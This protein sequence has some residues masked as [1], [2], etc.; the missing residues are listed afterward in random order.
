MSIIHIHV[1]QCGNQ[2]A[3]PLWDLARTSTQKSQRRGLFD[4][5][6]FARAIFVDSEPK[7]VA[8]L[9][10]TRN[11]C[12]PSNVCLDSSGRGNSWAMGFEACIG[13]GDGHERTHFGAVEESIRREAERTDF[14][15]SFVTYSSLGGGTGSGMGSAILQLLRYSR[16]LGLQKVSFI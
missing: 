2:V 9:L 11:L 4:E 1:G 6:G 13:S 14:L 7:V 8:Q 15:R 16:A 12:R 5:E 3:V 10:H